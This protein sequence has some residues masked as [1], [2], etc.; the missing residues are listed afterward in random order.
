MFGHI[1]NQ[2][3]VVNFGTVIRDNSEHFC[4]VAHRC[5]LKDY[6]EEN[7]FKNNNSEILE[8]KDEVQK[9]FDRIYDLGMNAVPTTTFSNGSV[10]TD[11]M[12]GKEGFINQGNIFEI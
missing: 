2:G 7:L 4:G 9:D 1:H 8:Y 11:F 12:F 10:V 6:G 3:D 5:V